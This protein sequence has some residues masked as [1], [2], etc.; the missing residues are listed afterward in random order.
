MLKTGN[1]LW[2]ILYS[3]K[4]PSPNVQEL[5]RE[6]VHVWKELNIYKF[7]IRGDCCQGFVQRFVNLLSLTKQ[8]HTCCGLGK[9]L[10]SVLTWLGILFSAFLKT[11]VSTWSQS[12]FNACASLNF[13]KFTELWSWK[14]S[15]VYPLGP[16]KREFCPVRAA[17][18]LAGI[19]STWW[20]ASFI[21]KLRC[22]RWEN[23]HT[24]VPHVQVMSW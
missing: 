6:V 24:R 21:F 13:F 8:D 22:W 7:M 5:F 18:C 17:R 23:N 16:N 10:H 1:H 12:W 19:K 3:H 15:T 14:F 2:Q 11:Q 20:C 9:F 4:K